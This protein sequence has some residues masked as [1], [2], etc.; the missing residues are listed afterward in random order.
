MTRIQHSKNIQP[1][2]YAK[3]YRLLFLCLI[4]PL[5]LTG[6][7]GKPSAIETRQSL[8]SGNIYDLT[9]SFEKKHDIGSDLN[10][11]LNLGRLYQ[12][13]G[14]WAESITSF[15]EA[16][17]IID[18]YESRAIIN[19]REMSSDVGM[20]SLSRGSKGYFGAGYERSLLHTINALNYLMLGDLEGAAVELRKM[21]KR[22][23]Y[24]LAETLERT[25]KASLHT[26]PL[27]DSEKL[28][29]EYS[30]RSTMQNITPY[31]GLYASQ[32]PFSYSLSAVIH[33]LIEN[34]DYAE[35]SEKRAKAILEQESMADIEPLLKVVK[36]N[37]NDIKEENDIK[38]EAEKEIYLVL[39]GFSGIAPSLYMESIRTYFPAIGYLKIDLP[40]YYPAEYAPPDIE[41]TAGSRIIEPVTLLHVDNLANQ[42]LWTELK[43]E[44][45]AA[46][47]R[48][49]LRASIAGTAYAIS[50]S[51]DNTNAYAD[52][53]GL[54]TTITLDV[55]SMM[56]DN[57]VRN[58][59]TLP[60][61]AFLG[62][63]KVKAGQELHIRMDNYT[64]TITL[65][66]NGNGVIV[67]LSHLPQNHMRVDYAT[68]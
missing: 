34:K 18:E 29:V 54:L 26:T 68:Y 41:I 58:W 62:V 30:L 33:Y 32:D 8:M 10:T 39:I 36:E 17:S 61:K 67:L 64:K 45:G 66:A 19:I 37:I 25:T 42:H 1:L 35:I 53:I 51:N 50:A 23:E 40:S 15:N 11:A 24:W 49:V 38:K 48:A 3:L 20:F 63:A 13:E 55:I 2:P 47:S 9:T 59:D 5:P 46:I 31:A 65:P 14:Q 60:A 4:L 7:A 57:E 43:Y 22:Q 52:G 44:T 12:L 6:C 21:E 27:E 28:P 16:T 56:M